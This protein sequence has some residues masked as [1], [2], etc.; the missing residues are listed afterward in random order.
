MQTVVA[1]L[2]TRLQQPDVDDYKKLLQA[3]QYLRGTVNMPLTLESDNAHI[4]KW[5]VD[6]SFTVYPDMKSHTGA[7]MTLGKGATYGT[8]T[9]QKLKMKSSTEG[10]LVRVNGIMPQVLWT[11]YFFKVQGYGV[12]DSIVYQDNQSTILLKKNGRALSGKRKRHINIRYF[13][14]TQ[15]ELPMTQ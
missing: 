6:A 11:H 7:I 12:E 2:T 3:M 13:C 15:T 10:R 14:V 1:F 8:S 9:C 5:W 4:I